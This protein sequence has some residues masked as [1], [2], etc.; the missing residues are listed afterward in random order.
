MQSLIKQSKGYHP[1]TKRCAGSPQV[2]VTLSYNVIVLVMTCRAKLNISP[3]WR[4]TRLQFNIRVDSRTRL[5]CAE[6]A[7]AVDRLLLANETGCMGRQAARVGFAHIIIASR[8][9]FMSVVIL[10]YLLRST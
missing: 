4:Y 9:I 5:I 3:W 7:A 1:Y 2:A 6:F 8:L 10:A